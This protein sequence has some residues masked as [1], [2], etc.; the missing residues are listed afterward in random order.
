MNNDGT[1]GEWPYS[2][3]VINDS[4]DPDEGI[5]MGHA[6]AVRDGWFV[7]QYSSINERGENL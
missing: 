7:R 6:Y 3:I 4:R 5:Q 2:Y 1:M